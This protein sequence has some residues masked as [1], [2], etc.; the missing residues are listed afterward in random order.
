MQAYEG[1]YWRLEDAYV[2]PKPRF[3]RPILVNATGSPAGFA[4]AA[5]HSDLVFITSPAGAEIDAAVAALPAHVA[6]LKSEARAF[7]REVRAIIN[8]MIVCRPTEREA[9]DYHAAILAH[10]DTEAL[11]GFVAHHAAGDSR[12]WTGHKAEHRVLGGNVQIIGSPEQVVDKLLALKAAGI[13]GVQLTF[14]DFAPDLAF[15][16]EA[17][18]PLLKQAG[19][20]LE[21]DL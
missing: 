16:G 10:A 3:G 5:A 15:F 18:L 2:S 4:Y 11:Q 6:K 1:R 8:P 13:D 14:F 9:R 19:L 12:A 17:V 20:R 7:G 21:H